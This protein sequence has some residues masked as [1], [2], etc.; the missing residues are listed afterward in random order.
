MSNIGVVESP[1]AWRATDMGSSNHWK[2]RFEPGEI[3]EID[4]GLRH[5]QKSGAAL[6][7]LTTEQFPLPGFSSVLAELRGHLETGAG[8]FLYKGFPVEQYSVD[9]LRLIYWGLAVHL[10][11]PVTQSKF[12][13]LLGDVR[14]MGVDDK[15]H[16]GRGY[17]SSGTLSFHSDAADVT[18]LFCLQVAKQGGGSM[19]ASSV[20]V[21]N[22][23]AQTRPDLLAV[24]Y[25]P[26]HWSWRGQ[27][28]PTE[29]AIY[30]QPVYGVQDG[31]FA[32][33]LLRSSINYSSQEE[34]APPQTD[35]QTEALDYL[36]TVVRKPEFH[37]EMMFEPG[38]IQFVNN[39]VIYH[40]RRAF[41]DDP[42]TGQHRHLLRLWL[43][44][45]NSRRLPAS[46][47]G[48]YKDQSPGAVRGGYPKHDVDAVYETPQQELVD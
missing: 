12:G 22:E 47:S 15:S 7:A 9:E 28:K 48:I 30:I 32:S 31:N 5:A 19:L 11:T 25:A 38:D 17:T 37:F 42:D 44:M 4:A 6:G 18:G 14:D 36:E 3:A 39:H 33:R 46:F 43:S 40:A 45:P 16:A 8:V 41:E 21:H 35:A 27:N 26:F 24:L 29:S 23:I 10:G 2:R 1:A 13:D 34:G 20:A